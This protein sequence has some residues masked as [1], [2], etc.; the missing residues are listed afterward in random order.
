MN[1]FQIIVAGNEHI[2]L[3]WTKPSDLAYNESL[4][5]VDYR[6][7]NNAIDAFSGNWIPHGVINTSGPSTITYAANNLSNNLY[8]EFR[9]VVLSHIGAERVIA[10]TDRTYN[11]SWK[12]YFSASGGPQCPRNLVFSYKSTG[13][14]LSWSPPSQIRGSS[15]ELGAVSSNTDNR[16]VI[17]YKLSSSASWPPIT[18]SN[19]APTILLPTTTSSVTSYIFRNDIFEVGKSYDFRVST[20]NATSNGSFVYLSVDKTNLPTNPNLLQRPIWSQQL[21]ATTVEIGPSPTPTKTVT[22]TITPTRSPTKNIATTPTRS[23]TKNITIIQTPTPT[24][25]FL[26]VV[27][28]TRTPTKIPVTPTPLGKTVTNIQTTQ[29]NECIYVSWDYP[30]Q[31]TNLVGYKVYYADNVTTF[32]WIPV[33][34][35]YTFPSNMTNALVTNLSNSTSYQIKIESIY[36]DGTYSATVIGST[37]YSKTTPN[38]PSVTLTKTTPSV[39]DISWINPTDFTIG[40]LICNKKYSLLFYKD[41]ILEYQSDYSDT[42]F[43]ATVRD[44][45]GNYS[46]EVA[47]KYIDS[48]TGNEVIVKSSRVYTYLQPVTPTPTL[49]ITPTTTLTPTPT[50]PK[51]NLRPQRLQATVGNKSV[52]LEW[53]APTTTQFTITDLETINFSLVGYEIYYYNNNIVTKFYTTEDKP[54]SVDQLSITIKGIQPRLYTCKVYAVYQ[55]QGYSPYSYDQITSLND[56]YIKRYESATIEFNGASPSQDLK[57]SPNSLKVVESFPGVLN[58]SWNPPQERKNGDLNFSGEYYLNIYGPI[59]SSGNTSWIEYEKNIGFSTSYTYQTSHSGVHSFEVIANYPNVTD[60]NND[61]I[62]DILDYAQILSSE[63]ELGYGIISKPVSLNTKQYIYDVDYIVITCEFDSGDLNLRSRMIY[64]DFGQSTVEDYLGTGKRFDWP[65]GNNS[66]SSYIKWVGDKVGSP[67]YESIIID[68]NEIKLD[69][70]NI[71]EIKL[72]LRAYW[73]GTINTNP[74]KIYADLYQSGVRDSYDLKNFINYVSKKRINGTPKVIVSTNKDSGERFTTFKYNFTNKTITFDNFDNTSPFIGLTPTPTKTITPSI[75][76]T[77]TPTPT[78]T[79]RLISSS[80]CPIDIDAGILF[81]SLRGNQICLLINLPD[82]SCITNSPFSKMEI[83]PIEASS[84]SY[85]SSGGTYTSLGTATVPFNEIIGASG[86]WNSTSFDKARVWSEGSTYGYRNPISSN[87]STNNTILFMKN[88]WIMDINKIY[89]IQVRLSNNNGFYTTYF[90]SNY[91]GNKNV[92]PG[93]FTYTTRSDMRSSGFGQKVIDSAYVTPT[94]TKT[95]TITTTPSITITSTQTKTPTITVTKTKNAPILSATPTKTK[96]LTPTPTITKPIS[97]FSN[98]QLYSQNLPEAPQNFTIKKYLGSYLL[99]WDESL[100]KQ[101]SWTD[102]R[103]ITRNPTLNSYSVIIYA[104]YAYTVP[105]PNNWQY[106][107]IFGEFLIRPDSSSSTSSKKVFPITFSDLKIQDEPYDFN[108][109]PSSLNQINRLIYRIG[110]TANYSDGSNIFS[111]G[112]VSPDDGFSIDSIVNNVNI[113]YLPVY[114]SAGFYE[115]D[116]PDISLNV[117]QTVNPLAPKLLA[118]SDNGTFSFEIQPLSNR[119]PVSYVFEII[120]FSNSTITENLSAYPLTVSLPQNIT[121]PY[122]GN[123]TYLYKTKTLPV[124]NYTARMRVYYTDRSTLY[125]K[126]ASIVSN[127]VSFAV[128][129]SSPTPITTDPDRIIRNLSVV[130]G[131]KSLYITFDQPIKTEYD[132]LLGYK[133]YYSND[134]GITWTFSIP[135]HYNNGIYGLFG[136]EN[137][138]YEYRALGQIA[139]GLTVPSN[140]TYLVK[141]VSEYTGAESSYI[142]PKQYE[143]VSDKVSTNPNSTTIFSPTVNYSLEKYKDS[144]AI[145]FNI[146]DINDA[147]NYYIVSNSL[148]NYSQLIDASSGEIIYPIDLNIAYLDVESATNKRA[149]NIVDN[150]IKPGK[151][152]YLK[153][154]INSSYNFSIFKRQKVWTLGSS[155]N[156]NV[157]ID[158][159][160]KEYTILNNIASP[161]PTPTITNLPKTSPTPTPTSKPFTPVENASASNSPTFDMELEINP[162]TGDYDIVI[163]IIPLSNDRNNFKYTRDL[164]PSISFSDATASL[165]KTVNEY[166]GTTTYSY[167]PGGDAEGISLDSGMVD[168]RIIF[169][170]Q[171]SSGKTAISIPDQT[172]S[173]GTRSVFYGIRYGDDNSLS[174]IYKIKFTRSQFAL[175]TKELGDGKYQ[176]YAEIYVTYVGSQR[177]YIVSRAYTSI[178]RNDLICRDRVGF[179]EDPQSGTYWASSSFSPYSTVYRILQVPFSPSYGPDKIWLNNGKFYISNNSSSSANVLGTLLRTVSANE[180]NGTALLSGTN[181]NSP[182]CAT[183]FGYGITNPSTISAVMDFSCSLPL[184]FVSFILY[185]SDNSYLPPNI[186]FETSID[187]ISWTSVNALVTPLFYTREVTLPIN[188]SCRYFRIRTTIASQKLVLAKF[189]PTF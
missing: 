72:D 131:N 39:A 33:A 82:I 20:L 60:V 79:K 59:D 172:V 68:L 90:Y 76:T 175:L 144:L 104:R 32:Q 19:S 77:I 140:G 134:N 34:F 149:V 124:G 136:V 22:S 128:T 8:Y 30:A 36:N 108:Y 47:T 35:G 141:V 53:S 6:F 97:V 87:G 101:I 161:T 61:G 81:N 10:Q 113:G 148:N 117:N 114:K 58:L 99:E 143:V 83:S 62:I 182:L 12:P 95:P 80:G 146:V 63:P 73:E 57:N 138:P 66:S 160:S 70:Q 23:P 180:A 38:S 17:Q 150:F 111:I 110:L 71:N 100:I 181:G 103:G 153:L 171:S 164:G 3:S 135:D 132:G 21:T 126:N 26:P 51:T 9:L 177:R 118:I 186:V 91:I 65:P 109:N 179:K 46:F 88:D 43:S 49:T 183:C 96:T 28:V 189:A 42:I 155:Y 31:F 127:T 48:S 98:S 173:G 184:K 64:P 122:R 107:Q 85:S 78:T 54:L 106:W 4:Y 121:Y 125:E 37:S 145:R 116:P 115:L 176:I 170:K 7:T 69:Y 167:S 84:L 14:T 55:K 168:A 158:S 52:Y 147:A 11:L 50:N 137:I 174:P 44:K 16:Y 157:Y 163:K 56:P 159:L 5:R 120:D 129:G 166:C 154:D 15:G 74:V 1:N 123:A 89:Y 86:V 169:Y 24:T 94:P 13:P 119:I 75:T 18:S 178:S 105:L 92:I 29:G 188:K 162:T 2:S 185:N 45:S 156:Y 112:A 102:D 93:N 27:T 165:P 151:T 41:N 67:A 40:N 130:A 25:S 187:G 152:Y 133:I 139:Y 142:N